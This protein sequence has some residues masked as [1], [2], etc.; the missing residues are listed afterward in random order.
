M[1]GGHVTKECEGKGLF[2]ISG[3]LSMAY[4]P[5]IYHYDVMGGGGVKVS[6]KWRKYR[7][8]YVNKHVLMFSYK[9]TTSKHMFSCIFSI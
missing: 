6:T 3:S 4:R 9:K 7:K 8:T 1:S 5:F 2:I